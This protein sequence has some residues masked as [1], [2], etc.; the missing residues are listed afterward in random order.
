MM[1]SRFAKTKRPYPFDVARALIFAAIPL[2]MATHVLAQPRSGI[3]TEGESTPCSL[4][5]P[6]IRNK[7]LKDISA[8]A[9][10][11]LRDF[12]SLSLDA[13]PMQLSPDGRIVAL[14]LRR[15]DPVTNRYCSA[16]VLIPTAGHSD[17][18]VVDDAGE[19]ERASFDKYGVVGIPLGIPKPPLI[20]WDPTGR[21]LAYVKQVG[22]KAEIWI[23]HSDGSNPHML[24]RSDVDVE[25]MEWSRTSDA[26]I[27]RNR[28]GLVAARQEIAREG[29]N[30]YRYDERFWPL[31][32]NRPLPSDQVPAFL[33][34]VDIGSAAV[35]MATPQEQERLAPTGSARPVG[36]R[37]YAKI[38]GN[39]AAWSIADDP[40][41]FRQPA[42]LHA[43]IGSVTYDC[44]SAECQNVTDVW[45]FGETL[46]IFATREGATDERTGLYAW[47]PGRG[48]PRRIMLTNDALF[49]CGPAGKRLIC[50][51][52][53]SLRPRHIISIKV[54]TGA[55]DTIFE[56]NPEFA[57]YRLGTVQRLI[58]KNSF[59]IESFGDLVL[60]AGRQAKG[61]L[62]LVIVQYESRGFLRGGTADEY[63][64]QLLAARGF[65]VLSFNKPKAFALHGPAVTYDE[66]LQANQ[67]GWIDR[68]SILSALETIIDRLAH[69]GI[70]DPRRVAITGQSDGAT[71]ATFALIHSEK[72]AA[73]ALSTCCEDPSMMIGNGEGYQKWY[74]SF[75][76]PSPG[77]P[78]KDF[79]SQS[80]LAMHAM[81][82]PVP[83]LIQA[84]EEEYRMALNTYE[85]LRASKW[86][87][88]MYIFPSEGH[89]KF[90]PAHRLAVYRRVVDWLRRIFIEPMING[91]F[92]PPATPPRPRKLLDG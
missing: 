17:P 73:A 63:P 82:R 3:A 32:S 31:G 89:V 47:S 55:A 79:W 18:R 13:A 30:G 87:I 77:D 43:R 56:P 60:P 78:A 80:S 16:L 75:G 65:A 26:L 52:E 45:W 85:V 90:Q 5:N 11:G 9:L 61:P 88:E 91:S 34:T 76:Y 4:P 2:S 8:E 50:A 92:V 46:L 86:P 81:K 25:A 6:A 66:Y 62:P 27:F 10:I 67:K 68:R 40:T 54:D 83:I 72:F 37:A 15:A 39:H 41:K 38:D 84:S 70:V 14:Q 28:P 59:G 69:D 36:T 24:F 33:Q 48:S 29:L 23:V 57:Q 71:T 22:G 74:E 58:W 19:I 35:R 12:G 1:T 51:R 21:S 64:I 20:R 42:R 44:A 7:E 49:G 53:T